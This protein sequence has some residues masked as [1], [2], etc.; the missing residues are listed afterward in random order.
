MPYFKIETNRVTDELKSEVL[1]KHAS[2]FLAKLLGKPEKFIMVSYNHVLAMLFDGDT[3]PAAY[4]EVKGIGLNSS[5]C[6][7]YS[8]AICE[9]LE[10]EIGIS[11]DRVYIDFANI[12]G[13]M[14]GWNKS[15]F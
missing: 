2:S 3:Q 15:V 14:F 7:D 9:F 13:K 6:S 11:P 1:V 8:K 5:S 12:D 10:S 4:V